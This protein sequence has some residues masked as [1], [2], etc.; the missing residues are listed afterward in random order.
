MESEG[1][2]SILDQR[3]KLF[4][5]AK[6]PGPDCLNLDSYVKNIGIGWSVPA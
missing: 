2:F 4:A 6:G 1:Y 3:R 5:D